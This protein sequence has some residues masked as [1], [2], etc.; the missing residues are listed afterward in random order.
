MFNGMATDTVTRQR[1][2]VSRLPTR[3]GAPVPGKR[4]SP[5]AG[6]PARR[7][8][9]ACSGRCAGAGAIGW[10]PQPLTQIDVAELLLDGL[11][12]PGQESLASVGQTMR[13]LQARVDVPEAPWCWANWPSGEPRRPWRDADGRWMDGAQGWLA[14][15]GRGARGA[16]RLAAAPWRVSLADAA[17]S[18]GQ[19]AGVTAGGQAGGAGRD[20]AAAAGASSWPG[21]PPMAARSRPATLSLGAGGRRGLEPGRLGYQ[22]LVALTPLQTHGTLDLADLP[23]H[24][25]AP[26]FGDA[27]RLELLRADA[28]FRARCAMPTRPLAPRCSWRA[29]ARW[30]S[31]APTPCRWPARPAWPAARNCCRGRRWP[32]TV[33]H[34]CRWRQASPRRWTMRETALSDFFARVIIKR[35]RPSTCRIWWAAGRH[36]HRGGACYKFDRPSAVSGAAGQ[37]DEKHGPGRRR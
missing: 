32:C 2:R 9:R 21:W 16:P 31:C 22:G 33:G 6:R 17:V 12:L 19:L 23:L 27:L 18:S 1:H 35:S 20:G 11:S 7:P 34:R 36:H 13:L 4:S 24:A 3:A 5:G 25:L 10:N 28:S 26:Y 29:T 8:P 15:P 30:K 14:A 37:N